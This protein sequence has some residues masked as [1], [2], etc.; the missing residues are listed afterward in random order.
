MWFLL[1]FYLK[2]WRVKRVIASHFSDC[3]APGAMASKLIDFSFND[4]CGAYAKSK[5]CDVEFIALKTLHFWL[6]RND[7]NHKYYNDIYKAYNKLLITLSDYSKNNIIS[8][9]END[10]IQSSYLNSSPTN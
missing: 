1:R 3:V 7:S 2:R 4:I 9:T 8:K 5:N 10:I 6:Y